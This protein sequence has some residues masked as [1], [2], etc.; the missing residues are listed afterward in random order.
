MLRRLKPGDKPS[1]MTRRTLELLQQQP[2]RSEEVAAALDVKRSTAGQYLWALRNA[3]LAECT[4]RLGPGATWRAL[5]A[6][7]AAAPRRVASVWEL[8]GPL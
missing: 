2:M 5:P 6:A 7:Q 1:P 8:G 4:P 3:G